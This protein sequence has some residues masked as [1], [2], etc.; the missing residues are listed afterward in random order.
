MKMTVPTFTLYSAVLMALTLR[1]VISDDVDNSL[2][3]TCLR[4]NGHC[5]L[6]V[7]YGPPLNTL[8]CGQNVPES[9]GQLL[10]VSPVLKVTNP[11]TITSKLVLVMFDPDAPGDGFMHWLANVVFDENGVGTIDNV[12]KDYYP[13]TPP[14]NDGQ[15]RYQISIYRSN[16]DIPIT[17]ANSRQVNFCSFLTDNSLTQLIAVFQFKYART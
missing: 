1:I 10:S 4:Y 8:Q 9:A 13:P 3:D 11:L 7:T 15:H 12:I 5:N 14:R 17:V 2:A 16:L 6:T